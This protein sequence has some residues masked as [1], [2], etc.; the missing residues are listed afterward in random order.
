MVRWLEMVG[1]VVGQL[2]GEMMVHEL[3]KLRSL[4]A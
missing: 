3:G 2:G 1:L 4:A